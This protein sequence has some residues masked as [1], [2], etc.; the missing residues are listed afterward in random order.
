MR[1]W[2]NIHREVVVLVLACMAL[3]GCHGAE[4]DSPQLSITH[5]HI[6]RGAG[7]AWL[8]ASIDLRPSVV[9]MDALQH[10]V[11]LVLRM[12]IAG[13]GSAPTAEIVLTLRYFP[14]SR[15][16][17]LRA[18]PGED[19]RSFALRGYL[20]DALERLRVHLP[21]DPCV[22]AKH[23]RLRVNFDYAAL[24]GA[25]RL[26]ALLEPSWR[27]APVSIRMDPP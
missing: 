7:D 26:P 5:A 22:G 11:P 25:L 20:F 6:E 15:R 3:G 2:K 17:Q 21:R 9:Q 19:D 13:D 16:Y 4:G 14:L 27:V 12:T 18:T 24:P 1:C 23:C 10:G 8:R